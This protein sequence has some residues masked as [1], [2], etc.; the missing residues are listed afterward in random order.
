M[1]RAL[2][3]RRGRNRYERLAD[4]SAAGLLDGKLTRAR[5]VPSKVFSLSSSSTKELTF[6]NNPAPVKPSKKVI[7][8]HP[9]LNLFYSGRK[10]KPTAK[11]EFSRYLQYVKEGGVWDLSSNKPVM[12]YK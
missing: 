10:K 2:S 3:T 11:P 9:L 7:K 5:S 6:P 12:H 1:F 4:E 8:S